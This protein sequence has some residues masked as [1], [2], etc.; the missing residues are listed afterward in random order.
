M[1]Y[2]LVE[3]TAPTGYATM[4][5]ISFTVNANGQI[6]LSD[7]TREDVEFHNNA[8]LVDTNVWTSELIVYDSKEMYLTA[9]RS[10]AVFKQQI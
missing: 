4:T 10:P 6:V 3:T 2:V 5:P 1:E 9:S 8:V 7:G